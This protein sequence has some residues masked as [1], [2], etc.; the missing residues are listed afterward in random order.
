MRVCERQAVCVGS[1]RQTVCVGSER[2]SVCVDCER[3]TVRVVCERKTVCVCSV[4]QF[5][6]LGCERRIVCV[7]RRDKLCA[8]MG[9][10]NC[11]RLLEFMVKKEREQSAY[12][13]YAFQDYL[14]HL[15]KSV[16]PIPI[17]FCANSDSEKAKLCKFYVLHIL[18]D[19]TF[20]KEAI[21]CVA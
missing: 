20:I 6:C 3:H 21:T 10:T 7:Y 9:E 18:P 2:Q 4:R 5:V 8:F 14:L 12:E 19:L 15:C 1:E 11:V 13:K 16:L 17:F